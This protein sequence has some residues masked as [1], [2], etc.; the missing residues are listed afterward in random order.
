M[1]RIATIKSYYKWPALWYD[2]DTTKNRIFIDNFSY[3]FTTLAPR[4]GENF[5]WQTRYNTYSQSATVDWDNFAPIQT[6]WRDGNAW[7]DSNNNLYALP[8]IFDLW[9]LSLDY[10]NPNYRA[11]RNWRSALGRN[12]LTYPRNGTTAD[13]YGDWW[14]GYDMN[15]RS[16]GWRHGDTLY[17]VHCMEQVEPLQWNA[18]G[19]SYSGTTVTIYR[20]NHGFQANDYIN[21]NG[22]TTT[23]LF[24]PNGLFVINSVANVNQF[25]YITGSTPTGTAGGTA[26]VTGTAYR[27]W[28]IEM[29]QSGSTYITSGMRAQQITGYNWVFEDNSGTA[30]ASRPYNT[31]LNWG[32]WKFFMGEDDTHVW[33]TRVEGENMCNTSVLKYAKAFGTGTETV[34]LANVTPN[35]KLINITMSLPSNLRHDT[36]TRKVFYT[37]H[38]DAFGVAPT[39]IV[40]DKALSTATNSECSE[41]YPAN[42]NY[43]T[44][45]HLPIGNNWNTFGYNNYWYKGHQFTIDGINYITFTSCDKF[46]Y[47]NQARFP[48]AKTRTWMTYT[49]APGEADNVLTFHSGYTFASTADFPLSWVPFNDQGDKIVIFNSSGTV[50]HKF[51][52]T[53]FT[54]DS[55]GYANVAGNVANVVTVTVNKENHGL[56]P[57]KFITTSGAAVSGN[58]APNGTFTVYETPNANVFTFVVDSG[59]TSSPTPS[60]NVGGNLYITTGWQPYYGNQVRARGY[61]VDSLGRLWVGSRNPA[62]A[63]IEVHMFSD[64]I[65]SRVDVTLSEYTSGS[66]GTKYIYSGSNI[67]SNIQI[68]AYNYYNERISSNILVGITSSNMIFTSGNAIAK[69]ITTSSSQ[70]TNVAVLITGPGSTQV[71][72]NAI[73]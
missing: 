4:F 44:Y 50:W 37:P 56:T 14:I 46:F 67:N 43:F 62:L 72:T 23:G 15:D 68:S 69:T 9:L 38:L 17:Y 47:S 48:N 10:T 51:D 45:S 70:P 27:G 24:P 49:I 20:P 25:T 54:A 3:D 34:V 58:G 32:G 39:R 60:G 31:S 11:T 2:P 66:N 6:G 71:T 22:T 63:R 33:Y 64:N 57:G 65:P 21:V 19:W 73:I 7:S 35:N 28:G 53:A 52:T 40:W 1:A 26:N 18:N 36:D 30:G 59:L 12:V 5:Y 41:I 13:Q 29:E 8:G 42:T 16:S 55:W 61:G